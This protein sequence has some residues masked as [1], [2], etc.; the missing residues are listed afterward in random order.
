MKLTKV[1]LNSRRPQRYRLRGLVRRQ[2]HCRRPA[3]E[4]RE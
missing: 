3:L 2:R 1:F 4:R